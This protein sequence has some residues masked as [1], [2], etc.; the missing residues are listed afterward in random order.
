M[1]RFILLISLFICQFAVAQEK[2][3]TTGL[4][5]ESALSWSEIKAK[6]KAENKPIFIDAWTTWCGP[7][8]YMNKKVFPKP[9]VGA[10]FNKNFINVKLQLDSTTEDGDYVKSWYAD[11]Q[12]LMQEWNIQYFPTFIFLDSKGEPVHRAVG[13]SDAKTFIALGKDALNHKSQFYTLKNK[14]EAGK[15]DAAL[16]YSLAQ[17]SNRAGI[18]DLAKQ[19]THQYLAT[20]KNIFTKNNLMLLKASIRSTADQG[21]DLFLQQGNKVDAI[22][23]KGEALN[24]VKGII[25]YQFLMPHLYSDEGP[26]PQPNWKEVEKIIKQ[27]LKQILPEYLKSLVTSLKADHLKQLKGESNH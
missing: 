27:E 4:V 9:E 20:Q 25:S 19:V 14:Y 16:L 23:G 13:G 3:E 1:N 17:A 5:F 24:F 2:K 7:C 11:A 26:I 10:F 15:R 8:V 12:K 18:D 22:L 21:F 6:A